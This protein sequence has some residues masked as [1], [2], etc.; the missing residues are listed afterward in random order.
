MVEAA[1][2]VRDFRLILRA[3]TFSSLQ[4]T[5]EALQE[6]ELD[7]EGRVKKIDN[8]HTKGMIVIASRC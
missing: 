4:K 6:A 5:L 2:R 8:S 1:D 7:M 3:D